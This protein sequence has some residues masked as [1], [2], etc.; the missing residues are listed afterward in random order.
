MLIKLGVDISRLKRECRR[1]LK[2][3]DEIFRKE[4][5]EAVVTSTYEGNHRPDT[6][7]YNDNAY[8]LRKP[9]TYTT[10][11]FKNLHNR[12]TQKGFDVVEEI[13]HYHIEY[14]PK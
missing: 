13:T 9:E 11:V 4:G 5:S 6:L 12:L 10:T 8:D 14:D 3:V 1:S 7:H 2:D